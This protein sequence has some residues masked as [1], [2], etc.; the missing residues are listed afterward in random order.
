MSPGDGDYGPGL[1]EW[2][3]YLWTRKRLILAATA[4]GL[5]ASFAIAFMTTP[6]YRAE[7]LLV[8]NSDDSDASLLAGFA[9]QATLSV[10]LW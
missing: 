6:V 2:L 3:A 5:I 7:V 8:P 9:S 1:G 10:S 4:L